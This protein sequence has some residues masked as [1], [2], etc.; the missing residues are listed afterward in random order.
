[1]GGC[2]V[3]FGKAAT[4]ASGAGSTS[5]RSDGAV[6]CVLQRRCCTCRWMVTPVIIRAWD[7]TARLVRPS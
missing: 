3:G 7:D 1:M 5:M 6:T 4:I 2:R